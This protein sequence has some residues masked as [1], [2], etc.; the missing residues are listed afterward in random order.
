MTLKEK[1]A[2]LRKLRKKAIKRQNVSSS[3]ISMAEAMREVSREA[4]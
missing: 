4:D 3:K 2:Q 1:K